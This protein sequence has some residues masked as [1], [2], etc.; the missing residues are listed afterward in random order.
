MPTLDV[1]PARGCY[2]PGET[3]ILLVEVDAWIPGSARLLLAAQHLGDP[4]EVQSYDFE[5][6]AGRQ[7][8]PIEWTPPPNPAGYSADVE[9]FLEDGT[10]VAHAVTAFDV[11]PSWT[12]YPRYGFLSDFG[13]HR[14]DPDVTLAQLARYHINGLQFYDWQ[15]RHDQ[16]LAP[17]DD[18]IDPLGRAVSLP[19][20]RNLVEAAHR[21]GMAALPYMAV[22]SASEEFARKHPEWALYDQA[23]KAITFGDNFLGLMNPSANGTWCQHLLSEAG[24]ALREIPFDGL[25]IDQYGEPKQAWDYQH[26]PVNLPQAFAEFIQAAR[27][28]QPDKTIL[29][30]AV[31]NWPIEVLATAS[32]DFLYIEI[33]PPDEKYE[34]LARIVLNAVHLSQGKVV[35][36]ALYLTADRLPNILLA[37]ALIM[38]CG[39]ARIELGESGR[40]LSD[41]YFPKHQ[42]IPENLQ[43]EL[44]RF[45]DFSIRNGEWLTSYNLPKDE[46]KIWAE[47]VLNPDWV[48]M[49]GSVW[50][51]AHHRPEGLCLSLVNMTG[52]K[53]PCWN[54]AHPAP[55]PR[56]NLQIRMKCSQKPN[57]VLWLCPEQ[58]TRPLSLD[59][60]FDNGK[61]SCVIPEIRY[62]GVII[63][64]D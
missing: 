16:L 6:T 29:L 3:V 59:F 5:L 20:V 62:L 4:A 31:G 50:S 53:D 27:N 24:R 40:L 43:I 58:Q 14:L 41:P 2:L 35:V 17:T 36:I 49:S 12:A 25:H 21:H 28:Q 47:G 52:L 51:I 10:L 57:R 1:Y 63:V 22:Y 37:D 34:Q 7:T 30:N 44:R 45:Y 33:W 8:V 26:T 9:L 13:K 42:A 32:L 11:L 60:K 61:L 15:Y 23:G 54:I 46:R 55:L 64:Y 19:I 38:A 48:T 18:Y 56:K 39:G